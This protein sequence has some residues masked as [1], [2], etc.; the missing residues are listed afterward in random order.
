ME[1]TVLVALALGSKSA[2][3]KLLFATEFTD[4]SQYY[5]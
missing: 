1:S 4:N 5:L 3:V 2:G